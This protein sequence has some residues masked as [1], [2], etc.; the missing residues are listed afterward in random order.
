[1]AL[2]K[3]A[4]LGFPNVG[5]STLFNR[6]IGEKKALVHSL[7]GMTRDK[8]YGT[9]QWQNKRFEVVDT[10]GALDTQNEPISHQ[11][12]EKALEA[13]RE[14]DI[15]LFV[16]DGR[17]ELLPI[18]K[19]LFISLKKL[20]KPLLIV[21]NKID[22]P[23]VEE[24]VVEFYKLGSKVF[25]I[26]AEHK[27]GIDSLLDAIAEILPERKVKE[28]PSEPLK[29]AIVGRINVGKSSIIN[30]LLGEERLI[31]S[32]IPGTTRDS[33]DTLIIRNARP[34]ILIDTAGIRKLGRT[35][36]KREKAAVIKAKKHI[37][38][39]DVI[40]LVV[41][42]LESPTHQDATIAQLAH[43]SS[44]PILV[45]VN[46]WDLVEK[47][48][49]TYFIFEKKISQKLSFID[50]APLIFI[51]A[52]TGKRVIK[53]LDIAVQIYE[54]SKKRI[55]TSALNKFLERIIERHP[56]ISKDKQPLKV[57]FISQKGIL[58]PTFALYCSKPK[59]LFPS[60]EKFLINQIR[61]EFDL[62]GTPI[63]LFIRRK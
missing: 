14:S 57:K 36:D 41:D 46:K 19:E 4:I 30:R 23:S 22:S 61:K 11:V 31:V 47:N 13:A 2:P 8:I 28:F 6:I 18:E 10:G 7:P 62:W 15:L 40:C 45:V 12:K 56:L 48:S 21:V 25:P 60:Y 38:W 43:L 51:S 52:L 59:Q 37:G 1:M 27:R 58:P 17:R 26:S 34:F 9:A 35:T 49:F 20:N 39:A 53:I 50:Y 29:I 24:K 33:T 44:K 3:V 63:K 54:N 5:K 32:D 16:L 42:A 55:L